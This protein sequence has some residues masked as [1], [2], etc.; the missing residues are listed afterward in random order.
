MQD[1]KQKRNTKLVLIGAVIIVFLFI[2]IRVVTTNNG[3]G[4]GLGTYSAPEF[5]SVKLPAAQNKISQFE[6]DSRKEQEKKYKPGENKEAIYMDFK[7]AYV[8]TDGNDGNSEPGKEAQTLNTVIQNTQAKKSN[9]YPSGNERYSPVSYPKKENAED[10]QKISKPATVQTPD[11]APEKIAEKNSSP[12]GTIK[13]EKTKP[14]TAPTANVK[15]EKDLVRAEI[16]GSQKIANGG[17]VIF[18]NTE[19][20]AGEIKIPKNSLLYGKASYNG[21]RVK[22]SVTRAKTAQ[23]DEIIDLMCFDNDYIEGIYFKAPMDE[24]VD[25]TK[26]DAG[27]DLSDQIKNSGLINKGINTVSSAVKNTADAIKK[28]RKLSVDDGYIVYLKINSK[29]K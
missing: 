15:K 6:E 24:A 29:K 21:D 9:E 3:Y 5:D 14:A 12:F 1:D 28:D 17:G 19:D 7:K 23:G 13:S 16:Y 10:V 25:K 22:I 2:V 26:D 4:G 20:I 8:K 11:P 18:R 27:L